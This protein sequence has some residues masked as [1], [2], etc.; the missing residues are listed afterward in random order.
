MAISDWSECL[1]C[2]DVCWDACPCPCHGDEE[3]TPDEVSLETFPPSQESQKVER[4]APV[5]DETEE[6]TS[7]G[8]AVIGPFSSP[9]KAPSPQVLLK[10]LKRCKKIKV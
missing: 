1:I 7:V 5:V 6:T 3:E 9:K 4:Q 8:S 2:E 10:K